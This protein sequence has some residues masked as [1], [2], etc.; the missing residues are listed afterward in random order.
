MQTKNKPEGDLSSRD[1]NSKVGDLAKQDSQISD[2]WEKELHDELQEF[3][4]V[5]EDQS[6]EH[7]SNPEWEKEIENMLGLDEEDDNE[8]KSS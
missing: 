4:F 3:E 2:D 5:S 6:G 7:E 8:K 1:E